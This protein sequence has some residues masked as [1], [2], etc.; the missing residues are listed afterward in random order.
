MDLFVFAD[1]WGLSFTATLILAGII[2]MIVDVFILSDIT[3]QIAYVIFAFTVAYNIPVQLM[4]RIIIG[5]L[6]WFILVAGHFLL[7]RKVLE[8]VA[9]KFIA[10][11]KYHDGV[12]GLVGQAGEVHDINGK[13]MLKLQ[14]DLW[15][16]TC[17]DILDDGTHVK[18]IAEQNGVLHVERTDIIVDL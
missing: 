4:Y 7:W 11:D 10:P 16:F 6:A 17:E 12:K 18:V 8:T 2:L 3:T 14:G 5:L 9:N 13:M 15:K 1:A